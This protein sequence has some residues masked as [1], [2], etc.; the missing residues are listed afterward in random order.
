M[1]TLIEKTFT[2]TAKV[3]VRVEEIGEEAVRVYRAS[4]S[5]RQV[6][7]TMREED[8]TT[9]KA[10]AQEVAEAD[11]WVEQDAARSRRLLAAVLADQAL[12]QQL[13]KEQALLALA[14]IGLDRLEEEIMGGPFPDDKELLAPVIA[15][16]PAEDQAEFAEASAED[17]FLEGND[18]YSDAFSEDIVEVSITEA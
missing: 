3:T 12:V 6:G 9:H 2:F 5:P 18:L 16:L 17:A 1:G 10:T 15:T 14:E 4:A 8:G 7:E 13:L 11:G